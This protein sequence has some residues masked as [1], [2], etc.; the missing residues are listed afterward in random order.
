[1]LLCWTASAAGRPVIQT[2]KGASLDL[3]SPDCSHSS[4][5][6]DIFP[7]GGGDANV[8]RLHIHITPT[9]PGCLL[10]SAPAGTL[11]ASCETFDAPAGTGNRSGQLN[12]TLWGV[13]RLLGS[14]NSGQNQYFDVA[15]TMIQLCGTSLQVIDP[16]VQIC[17]GQLVGSV[18]DQT[19]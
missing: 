7:V 11:P 9:S 6:R 17:G 13:S 5:A 19:G 1:V 16:L 14:T 12:G 2:L 8:C 15:A 3:Q 18:W 10:L 4:H